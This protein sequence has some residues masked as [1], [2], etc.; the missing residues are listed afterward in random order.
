MPQ[1]LDRYNLCPEGKQCFSQSRLKL[2]TTKKRELVHYRLNEMPFF[3]D[4]ERPGWFKISGRNN[5]QPVV[6][7]G[8]SFNF[9]ELQS[10]LKRI[11]G[12]PRGCY[13]L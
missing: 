3:P 13:A 7:N 2:A 9:R 12:I 10:I 6:G 11:I 1:T 4:K 8:G 5:E